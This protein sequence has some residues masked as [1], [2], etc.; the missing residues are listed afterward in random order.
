MEQSENYMNITE[1]THPPTLRQDGNPRHFT[2]QPQP[3]H[4]PYMTHKTSPL[5]GITMGPKQ[6]YKTNKIIQWNIRGTK[7]NLDKLTLIKNLHPSLICLQETFLKENNK[8]NIKQHTIYNQINKHT[9]ASIGTSI[10]VN[11]ILPQSQI[12]LNTNLQTIAVSATLHKTISICTLYIPSNSNIIELKLKDLIQLPTYTL[13]NRSD[14]K[15]FYDLFR[16]Q[17][18]NQQE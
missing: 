5:Q 2:H 7:A 16:L 3:V 12:S 9:R 6:T 15:Q 17:L 11:N 14:L 8:L 4:N 13:S 1:S 18:E 10:I